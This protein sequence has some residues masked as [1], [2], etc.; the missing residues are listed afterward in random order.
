MDK[1]TTAE[2]APRTLLLFLAVGV[3]AALVCSSLLNLLWVH[4]GLPD[5]PTL[6]ALAQ[7]ARPEGLQLFVSLALP[8]SVVL[9]SLAMVLLILLIPLERRSMAQPAIREGLRQEAVS[10]LVLPVMV[11]LPVIWRELGNGFLATGIIF[12]GTLSF[13]AAVLFRFL[14]KA[15]LSPLPGKSEAL[16]ARAQV[17]VF[18]AAWV[19]LGLAA[20]W[21]NQAVSCT[22]EEAGWL[23]E[24]EAMRRGPGFLGSQ[25]AQAQAA[26][27]FYWDSSAEGILPAISQDSVF[28]LFLSP[29]LAVGG[30]LGVLIAF[31]ALMALMA[32]QMLAWLDETG[33]AR[34]PAAAATALLVLSAPVWVAGQQVLPDVPA[35]LL[36]VLGLR[37]LTRMDRHAL[38]AGLGVVAVAGMLGWLKLRMAALGGGLLACAGVDLLWRRWGW[39]GAFISFFALCCLAAAAIWLVPQAWWPKAIVFSWGEILAE[40]QGAPSLWRAAGHAWAGLFLDQTYGVFIAAP[41]LLLALAGLPACLAL[42]PR[43]ALLALTPAILYFAAVCLIRWHLWYGG[44]AGPG[45]LIAVVLPALALPLAMALSGLRKPWWRLWALIPLVLSLSYTWLITLVPIWRY[46]LPTGVNPLVASLEEALGL[47]LRQ[48]L[49]SLLTPTLVLVPWLVGS[50]ALF[51]LW[52]IPVWRY[53]GRD[54][55]P[56]ERDLSRHEVLALVLICGALVMGGLA[57]GALA[58]VTSIEAEGMRSLKARPWAL[59]HGPGAVRGQSLSDGGNLSCRLYFAGGDADVKLVGKPKAVGRV[60]LSLDGRLFE[61]PWPVDQDSALVELGPVKQGVHNITVSWASCLERECDL[62]LDRVEVRQAAPQA[63]VPAVSPES[64]R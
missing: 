25:Q 42:R 34:K 1:Q 5:K 16:S 44:Q 45:R 22:N 63:S 31:A 33:V 55:Y 38:A 12:L 54:D 14:W 7:A 46:S 56:P 11:L 57:W 30:R 64:N 29:L 36:F 35:M 39:R 2:I 61:Q 49:P 19:V 18:I 43:A 52:A 28:A 26:A 4:Q 23:L 37:L 32:C 21:L 50:A 41:I 20:G 48:L 6:G 24:A 3:A 15:H 9:P 10:Y 13:K 53:T 47:F 51:L 62:N 59:G 17:V 58:H 27:G 40:M 8:A 60:S